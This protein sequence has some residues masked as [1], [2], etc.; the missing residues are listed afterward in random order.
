MGAVTGIS[1]PDDPGFTLMLDYV[2]DRD[3]D[4]DRASGSWDLYPGLPGTG[5]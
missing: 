1:L 5:S 2:K 4:R 3:R